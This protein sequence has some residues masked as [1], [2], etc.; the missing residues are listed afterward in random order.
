MEK[1]LVIPPGFFLTSYSPEAITYKYLITNIKIQVFYFSKDITEIVINFKVSAL[2]LFSYKIFILKIQT[3]LPIR[4]HQS[5]K[6][7]NR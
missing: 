4:K 6:Y 1:V 3:Q 7:I 5:A 2:D